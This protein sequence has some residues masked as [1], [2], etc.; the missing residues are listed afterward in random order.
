M[1][2][3]ESMRKRE[4][5]R[6]SERGNPSSFFSI[7]SAK[8]RN[9]SRNVEKWKKDQKVGTNGSF[10]LV[11]RMKTSERLGDNRSEP[12]PRFIKSMRLHQLAGGSTGPVYSLLCFHWK[13][14]IFN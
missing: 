2:D 14:N 12:T 11:Q 10:E 5:A 7:S 13:E 1:G 8:K 9:L 3:R 4:R 6:E